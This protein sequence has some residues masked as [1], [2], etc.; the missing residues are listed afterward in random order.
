MSSRSSLARLLAAL[1]LC[2]LALGSIA[3]G[4]SATTGDIRGTVVDP[5]GKPAANVR[6]TAVAPSGSYNATS[7]E[8][9]HYALLNVAPDTY[10]VSFEKQGFDTTIQ[11]GVT[12]VAG[13][14]PT[15]NAQLQ[16]RTIGG[17]RVVARAP[18]AFTPNEP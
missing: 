2:V 18:G 1:V 16:L 6:V 11:R 12:V 4:A 9:G 14:T 17:A 5:N 7:D 3:R 8:H 10:S 13:A 15:L